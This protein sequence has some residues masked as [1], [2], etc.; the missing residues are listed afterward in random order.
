MEMEVEVEV[1]A[2]GGISVAERHGV[3][4]GGAAVVVGGVHLRPTQHHLQARYRSNNL[5]K[6]RFSVN[7]HFLYRKCNEIKKI[8]E[9]LLPIFKK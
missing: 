8:C 1:E 5:A 4:E 2:L 7:L 6:I 9:I 3:E